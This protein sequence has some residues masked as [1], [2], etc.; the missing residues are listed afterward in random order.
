[1]GDQG[2]GQRASSEEKTKEGERRL[3]REELSSIRRSC[4]FESDRADLERERRVTPK[5]GEIQR[6]L[7]IERKGSRVL[8]LTAGPAPPPNVASVDATTN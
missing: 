8:E 3:T 2:V 4:E 1:M 7:S 6:A 5:S